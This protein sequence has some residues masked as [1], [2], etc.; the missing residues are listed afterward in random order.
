MPYK[1]ERQRRFMHAR[2]PDV[3]ARWDDKYGGKIGGKRKPKR[4][5][6]AMRRRAAAK[7]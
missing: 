1:S 6:E 5:K 7:T 4:A 2:H 3:A